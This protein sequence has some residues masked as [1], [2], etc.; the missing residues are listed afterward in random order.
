VKILGK[1][2]LQ[3]I[4]KVFYGKFKGF[5][6]KRGGATMSGSLQKVYEHMDEHF[7]ERLERLREFL[8]I[9]S[10]SPI[11]A[12]DGSDKN[13]RKAAEKTLSYIK[14]LGAED[15]RLVEV[16]GNPVV[17]GKLYSQNPDAKTLIC[18]SMYDVM[19]V[20]EPRWVVPPFEGTIVDPERIEGAPTHF[21]KLFVGRG[22]ANQKGQLMAFLNAV[23]TFQKVTGDIPVNIIFA[24]EGEEELGSP[25]FPE[26][27]Q[28]YFD[29]LKTADVCHFQGFRTDE[30]GR[31]M[32]QRGFKG[33]LTLELEVTGGDWGGPPGRSLFAADAAWVDAPILHLLAAANTLIDKDGNVLV[34]GFYDDVRPLTPTEQEE[35]RII[36]ETFDEVPVMENWQIR[37]FKQG[38]TGRELVG[39]YITAPLMNIDGIVGGYTG[40]GVWTNLPRSGLI[41]IDVRLVPDMV[42]EIVIEKL[43]SHLIKQGFPEVT[44]RVPSS[45][46][47]GRTPAEAEIIQAAVRATELLGAPY[48]MWPTW[49]GCMP[50]YIFNKA[51][52][53]LPVSITG[54]GHRARTH[55][56]NEYV[57]VEGLREGERYAATLMAEFAKMGRSRKVTEMEF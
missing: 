12:R 50:L 25:S 54:M 51:P 4:G 13:I 43:R 56:A 10:I 11:E 17:F 9:P 22:A 5:A 14:A 39:H 42:P 21:G 6:M 29:D 30:L 2:L 36:E 41:K 49:V 38:R 48:I 52:L 1:N 23:E 32:I 15:A 46:D 57:T 34:E 19:P 37:K 55:Q 31:H 7:D 20:D 33:M 40:P 16:A 45:Y 3:E 24:I 28:K 8:R 53:H 26:F 47:W 27:F 44:V 35:I 18:Y